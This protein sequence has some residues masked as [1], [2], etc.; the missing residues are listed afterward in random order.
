[1]AKSRVI[2]RT[3]SAPGWYY[4][5]ITGVSYE[6]NKNLWVGAHASSVTNADVDV[7]GQYYV[8]GNAAVFVS[9]HAG[10]GTTCCA[11]GKPGETVTTYIELATHYD[12]AASGTG[13]GY[14]WQNEPSSPVYC[15]QYP[16]N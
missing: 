9:C 5:Q 13:Y 8:N 3:V 7:F 12:G 14:A 11:G 10:S 6:S 16:A 15:P 1:M 4:D 2:P